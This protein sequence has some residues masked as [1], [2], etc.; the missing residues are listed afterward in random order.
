MQIQT[1]W[2]RPCAGRALSG[3]F[4]V[5]AVIDTEL[6]TI[7]AVIGPETDMKLTAGGTPV[8]LADGQTIPEALEVELQAPRANVRAPK[9]RLAREGRM[10]R[11]TPLP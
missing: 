5:P 8:V 1:R 11:I 3:E 2:W 7:R 4:N 9:A 6:G 10:L